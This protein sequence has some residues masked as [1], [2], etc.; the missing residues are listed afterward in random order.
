MHPSS[1]SL[2]AGA[3]RD[4]LDAAMAPMAERLGAQIRKD[5]E[6]DR[7]L[8]PSV[9]AT[10]IA[11]REVLQ[12]PDSDTAAVC[13]TMSRDPALAA[14]VL[15]VANS[16]AFAGLSASNSLQSAVV[17]LGNSVLD[18]VMLVFTISRIFSVGR[19][20]RIQPHLSRLWRHSAQV[21]ALSAVLVEWAPHLQRDVALLAGLI[22]DIG[23]VPVIVKAQQFPTLLDNAA[24]LDHLQQKL[25]SELGT[26][27]LESWNGP[28]ELVQVVLEHENIDRDG[29]AAADYTD[30]VL[31]A[32]LLSRLEALDSE[33]AGPIWELPASR[34]LG[35]DA[36]TVPELV[37]RAAEYE[38]ELNGSLGNA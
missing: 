21:A 35:V 18:N 5:A 22:H 10:V 20:A 24:L 15:R 30:L 9:P 17:R 3:S 28:A 12:D 19:R 32:N 25:H 6:L 23:S 37:A 34:K 16:P 33:A 7:L 8:L 38:A 1:V 11:V 29:P 26:L 4:F 31:V 14:R 2:P 27:V 13:R 36:T